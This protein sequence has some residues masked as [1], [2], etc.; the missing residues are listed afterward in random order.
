MYDATVETLWD[1]LKRLKVRT[2]RDYQDKAAKF[3][4]ILLLGKL[5][6][7]NWKELLN[8]KKEDASPE[9]METVLPRRQ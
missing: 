7:S 4:Q 2:K 6:I 8:N 5:H 1:C 9:E 3:I